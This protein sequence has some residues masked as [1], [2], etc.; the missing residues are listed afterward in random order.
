MGPLVS[1]DHPIIVVCLIA[2]HS[3]AW[4][5]IDPF[6]QSKAGDLDLTFE[7]LYEDVVA[8]MVDAIRESH[9]KL[10]II[11][12]LADATH[13]N[14]YPQAPLPKVEHEVSDFFLVGRWSCL[15]GKIN[16]PFRRESSFFPIL[17][18]L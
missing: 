14:I 17:V 15:N 1:A 4:L 8:K 10:I 11:P 16:T 5:L 12:S 9:T 7:E 18:L 3:K 13:D 6:A 2:F